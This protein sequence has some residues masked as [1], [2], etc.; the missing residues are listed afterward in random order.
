IISRIE[1]KG[2]KLVGG[3]F[4]Q[5]PME[6]AEKHYSEHE[7]KPFYD[8][9]ISFI[10]SAPVFA[11]VVEGENAVA[12]SRKIIGSTNPS[13]AAPGT[14]RGDY[15]LNLGRNIIHGSDSTESAQREVKL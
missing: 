14:I 3:K 6:L 1:K 5:V 8:K 15:G 12:V 7:G 13:E 9:L 2:L 4:M 11:M 10:T